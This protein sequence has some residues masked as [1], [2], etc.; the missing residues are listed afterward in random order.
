MRPSE[1]IIAHIRRGIAAGHV[2]LE[3]A[4]ELCAR[5]EQ[6]LFSALKMEGYVHEATKILEKTLSRQ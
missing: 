2:D 1:E 4:E 3:V 5:M 6:T